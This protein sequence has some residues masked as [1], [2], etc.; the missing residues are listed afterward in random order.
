[1]FCNVS[2]DLERA[3]HARRTLSAFSAHPPATSAPNDPIIDGF[4]CLR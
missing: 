2:P 4:A 1:M 3:R